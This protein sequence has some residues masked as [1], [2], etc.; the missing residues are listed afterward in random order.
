[1]RCKHSSKKESVGRVLVSD[2]TTEAEFIIPDISKIIGPDKYE[3]VN[4]DIR[5]GLQNVVVGNEKFANTQ[6]KAKIFL[7]RLK[8]ARHAFIHD[9]IQPQI[10][11]IC[12]NLGF[13][14]FPATRF[15]QLDIKDEVQLQVATRLMEIGILTPQQGVD[16]IKPNLSEARRAVSCS[17]TIYKGKEKGYYNP[18]V[19]GVPLLKL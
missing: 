18:L 7:E 1:M 8:E 17:R 4:N 11:L 5:E 16:V 10:K 3:I 13:R 9:F 15:E 19:G 14:K 12:R 2:Y 6:V